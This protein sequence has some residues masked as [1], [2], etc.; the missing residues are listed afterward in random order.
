MDY[1]RIYDNVIVNAKNCNRRKCK[2]VYYENHHILPKCMGGTNNVENLVLLTAK[3]HF[4]CHMLLC[5]IYSDNK[6]KY[7]LFRLINSQGKQGY[8]VTAKTYERIK[9]EY[10][11]MPNIRKGTKCSDAT[12]EKMSLA[13]KG[14]KTS[15]DTKKKQSDAKLKFFNSTEGDELRKKMSKNKIDFFKTP[16]GDILKKELSMKNSGHITS[17]E[18]KEK[19]SEAGKNRIITEETRKKMSDSNSGE[20]HHGV[21][22]HTDEWKKQQS[23]RSK[24]MKR[25]WGDKISESKKGHKVSQETKDKISVKNKNRV[26]SEEVRKKLS[27]KTKAYW[28]RKKSNG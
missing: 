17:E 6:L 5:E 13:Q 28:E 9:L 16:E 8:R 15:D 23:E 10:S 7:A 4:V 22:K 2:G 27:E 14:R 18:T 11:K 19:I 12:K 20:K 26:V 25:T 21:K 3:E 1:K 24:N